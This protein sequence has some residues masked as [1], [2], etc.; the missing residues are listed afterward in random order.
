MTRKIRPFFSAEESSF[1]AKQGYL[2][3][4]APLPPF[5]E[6]QKSPL[7][8]DLWRKSK[9]LE[10]FLTQTLAPYLL[11]FGGKKGL[12]L[13]FDEWLPSPFTYETRGS[14]KD[15]FSIQGVELGV[16]FALEP[17]APFIPSPL[18]IAP[19]PTEAGH[20][21]LFK[22]A[23]LLDWPRLKSDIPHPG[24]YLAAYAGPDA[25]YICNPK[26]REGKTLKKWG[27]AY[28]DRLQNEFHPLLRG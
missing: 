2:E 20:L 15:F 12:R 19:L 18:G 23:L 13:A 28:G 17:P 8:R 10:L 4:E 27:Y 9:K 22:G 24:L 16:L 3:F 11:P 5:E 7:E 1:F 21:L 14:L 6:F 26:D 25:R